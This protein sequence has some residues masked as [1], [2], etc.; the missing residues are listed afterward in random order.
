MKDGWHTYR[1][2][3]FVVVV[4]VVRLRFNHLSLN[5]SMILSLSLKISC[6]SIKKQITVS[7]WIDALL[8]KQDSLQSGLKREA[9]TYLYKRAG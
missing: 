9:D 1:G 8:N 4:Q 6:A 5:G 7:S 2:E 3:E